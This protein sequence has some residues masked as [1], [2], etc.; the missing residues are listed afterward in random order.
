MI[1][2]TCFSSLS[3]EKH[4]KKFIIFSG[5]CF[6][7][8]TLDIINPRY[9]LR[10][11]ILSIVVLG[12]TGDLCSPNYPGNYP[13]N[14]LCT[15]T[16]T[17]QPWKTIRVTFLDFDVQYGD[18]CQFDWVRAFSGSDQYGNQIFQ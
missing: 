3:N 9:S 2:L 18:F 4:F 12:D 14:K 13:N 8:L 11:E 5:A 17:G 1:Y 10:N 7:T 6:W 15:W 16:I